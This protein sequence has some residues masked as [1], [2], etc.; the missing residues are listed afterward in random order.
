MQR[1]QR[2]WMWIAGFAV[3]VAIAFG[4]SQWTTV[5]VTAQGEVPGAVLEVDPFWPKPL[6]NKWLLGHV[7]G[8]AVDS[9]DHIWVLH[10]PRSLTDSE[11]GAAV[12]PPTSECC[13][14]APAVIEFDQEGDVVQAWGGPGEGYEWPNEEH[15]I[16]VD[17][18][19]NV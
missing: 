14:P 10:R 1:K 12:D 13:V 9:R 11:R 7:I 5:R 6:P 19:D 17:H 16:F 4:Y 15:G 3:A 8:V 2:P 18:L